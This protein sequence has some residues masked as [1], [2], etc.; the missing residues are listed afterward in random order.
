MSGC[1]GAGMPDDAVVRAVS[2]PQSTTDTSVRYG[3]LP[4]SEQRIVRTAV[5]NGFYHAC[6][7]LPDAVR[8]FAARFED[9]ETAHLSYR[10]TTYALWIRITDL[11][12]VTTAS[13]PEEDPSCGLF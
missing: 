8:S 12:R 6:P 1:L 5:E 3:A 13:P 11:V 4:E 10:G 9:P 7:E 2:D